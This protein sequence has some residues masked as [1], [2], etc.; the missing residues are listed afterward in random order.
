MGRVTSFGDLHLKCIYLLRIRMNTTTCMA[1]V[2]WF[3]E[4]GAARY[5]NDKDK[6]KSDMR[7]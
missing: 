3:W 7:S 2:T 4:C 1:D 5:V 6:D